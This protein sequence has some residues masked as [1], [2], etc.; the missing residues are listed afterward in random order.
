[1]VARQSRQRDRYTQLIILIANGRVY[2]TGCCQRCRDQIFRRGF[3]RTARDGDHVALECLPL[4]RTKA[5]GGLQD[6]GN[7]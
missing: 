3:T 6:V 2:L 1:M 4:E 5:P 7:H